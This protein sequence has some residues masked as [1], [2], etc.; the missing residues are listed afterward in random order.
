MM[1]M[2]MML[3]MIM[4]TMMMKM[5]MMVLMMI[6]YERKRAKCARLNEERDE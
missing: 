1:I 2:K 4:A 3:M 6:G 5:M